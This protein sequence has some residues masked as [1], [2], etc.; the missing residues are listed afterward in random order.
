LRV[1]SSKRRCGVLQPTGGEVGK[2][3]IPLP[4]LSIFFSFHR[5]SWLREAISEVW[6]PYRACWKPII[7]S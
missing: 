1:T 3:G 2:H 7:F 6:K 4:S 5:Y